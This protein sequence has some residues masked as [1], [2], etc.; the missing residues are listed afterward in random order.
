MLRPDVFKIA[1]HLPILA[2]KLAARLC[3]QEI[4]PLL[5]LL[6]IIGG[7]TQEKYDVS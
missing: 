1:M 6:L 4:A 5:L 2:P 7:I 3:C